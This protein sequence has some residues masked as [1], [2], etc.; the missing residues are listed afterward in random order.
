MISLLTESAKT[1]FMEYPV[2][3]K[4]YRGHLEQGRFIRLGWVQTDSASIP[5]NGLACSG[6]QTKLFGNLES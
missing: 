3:S 6:F 4:F 2:H 1:S 5:S